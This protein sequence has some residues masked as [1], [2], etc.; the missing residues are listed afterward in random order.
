M[1]P[2]QSGNLGK[3]DISAWALLDA[4]LR[5]VPSAKFPRVAIYYSG[6]KGSKS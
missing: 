3:A 6:S 1:S 2:Q 5:A 4:S